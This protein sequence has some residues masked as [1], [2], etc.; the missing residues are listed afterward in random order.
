MA[1]NQDQ[2][3]F[4]FEGRGTLERIDTFTTKNGKTILTL[5]V[6][7]AGKYPKRIPFKLFGQRAEEFNASPGTAVAITGYLSGSEW[8]SKTFP[9]NIAT[10]VTAIG[11]ERAPAPQPKPQQQELPPPPGDSEIPF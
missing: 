6:A 7:V 8:N 11:G 2:D 5:I 1:T 3:G 10:E 4:K 9:E